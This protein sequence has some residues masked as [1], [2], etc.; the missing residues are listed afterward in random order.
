[1]YPNV[2]IVTGK[3]KTTAERVIKTD[4]TAFD[5]ILDFIILF[6]FIN[7]FIGKATVKI[8]KVDKTDSKNEMLKIASGLKSKIML[9][10]VPKLFS[11][12]LWRFKASAS[13]IKI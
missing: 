13:D 5:R 2:G 12:L 3:V 1:M 4:S 9:T 7:S 8:P 11:P 6:S 10:A